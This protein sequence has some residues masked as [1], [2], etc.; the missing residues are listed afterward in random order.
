MTT[1]HATEDVVAIKTPTFGDLP[2]KRST[3]F[4]VLPSVGFLSYCARRCCGNTDLA[5][6][7]YVNGVVQECSPPSTSC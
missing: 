3:S 2:L 6:R 4:G 5:D 1:S 7:G